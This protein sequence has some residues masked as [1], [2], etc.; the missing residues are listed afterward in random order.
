MAI[1][2]RLLSTRPFYAELFFPAFLCVFS[3]FGF[4]CGASFLFAFLGFLP[5][6]LSFVLLAFYFFKD[7]QSGALGSIISEVSGIPGS[8]I[9]AYGFKGLRI[10]AGLRLFSSWVSFQRWR[11]H[12]FII[13]CTKNSASGSYVFW[14]QLEFPCTSSERW[15]FW[16]STSSHSIESSYHQLGLELGSNVLGLF[17]LLNGL[18]SLLLS[19]I[20]ADNSCDR[21]YHR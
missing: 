3:Y 12:W 21:G 2:S 20:G 7:S 15:L 14:P 5:S 10:T 9:I 4:F 19:P 6:F 13:W 8:H 18:N 11:C 16:S 1:R 17:G